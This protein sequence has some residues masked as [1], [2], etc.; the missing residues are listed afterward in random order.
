MNMPFVFL[1]F[2][3][4]YLLLFPFVV[5]SATEGG[6]RLCF[7][8]CL[9]LID[10]EQN[11]SKSCGRIWMKFGGELGYVTPTKLSDFGEDPYPDLRIFSV[12]FFYL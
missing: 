7:H 12:I 2:T 10:C 9:C 4:V 6:W 11:I 3:T 8:P 1:L 5:T